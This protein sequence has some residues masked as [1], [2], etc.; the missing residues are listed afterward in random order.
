MLVEIPSVSISDSRD[1]DEAREPL[2]L[3]DA[4]PHITA[5]HVTEGRRVGIE[6]FPNYNHALFSIVDGETTFIARRYDSLPAEVS[7]LRR[8]VGEQGELVERRDLRRPALR[9][10][11]RWFRRSGMTVYW[12]TRYGYR[13]VW[14]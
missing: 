4:P 9:A 3:A 5:V 14:C 7:I 11:F 10:A 8:E 13:R 6:N 12:L 1:D 2:L